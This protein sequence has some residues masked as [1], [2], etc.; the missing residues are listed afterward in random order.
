MWLWYLLVQLSLCHIWLTEPVSRVVMVLAGTTELVSCV[1]MVL[2]GT[3]GLMMTRV[4]L[5]SWP[6]AL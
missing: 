6:S 2:A 3:G 4:G 1:V 5:M